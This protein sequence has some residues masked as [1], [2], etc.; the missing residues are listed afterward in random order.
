MSEEVK[1]ESIENKLNRLTRELFGFEGWTYNKKH[2]SATFFLR[3]PKTNKNINF[4]SIF[5]M[6]DFFKKEIAK[7]INFGLCTTQTNDISVIVSEPIIVIEALQKKLKK[8][9]VAVVAAVVG[10]VASGGGF[11]SE[12]SESNKIQNEIEKLKLEIEAREKALT[13]LVL[14]QSQ[15]PSPAP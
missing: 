11:L 6:L 14:S 9:R 5:V 7:P 8:E 13:A 2:K 1:E 10:I 4:G 15:S 3:D 12:S